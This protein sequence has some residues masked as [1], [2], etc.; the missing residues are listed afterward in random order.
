MQR[1]CERG[2]GFLLS[3]V[4]GDVAY[5]LAAHA[6]HIGTALPGAK[7]Q[8]HRQARTRAD[9]MVRPVS[10]DIVLRPSINSFGAQLNVLDTKGWVVIAQTDLL[11]KLHQPSYYFQKYLRSGRRSA[12]LF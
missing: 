12:G 6:D 10:R 8:L 2:A 7:Q 1:Y 3:D 9:C 11:A 5:V 4:D